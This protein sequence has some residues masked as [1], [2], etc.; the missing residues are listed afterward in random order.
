LAAFAAVLA[1]AIPVAVNVAIPSSSA[2]SSQNSE[3]HNG[4]DDGKARHP[5]NLDAGAS[6][7]IAELVGSEA[8]LMALQ[9]LGS[10]ASPEGQASGPNSST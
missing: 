1:V 9:Q 10:P 6:P 2:A 5:R 3:G 7:A 4:N 8:S